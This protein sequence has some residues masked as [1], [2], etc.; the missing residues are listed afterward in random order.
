MVHLLLFTVVT[1]IAMFSYNL[2]YLSNIRLKTAGKF[3]FYYWVLHVATL[4]SHFLSKTCVQLTL[5]T[6]NSFRYLN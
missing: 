5:R 6:I 1:V 4:R 3:I 2:A